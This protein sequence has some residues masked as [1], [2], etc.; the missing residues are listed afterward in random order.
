MD[1]QTKGDEPF[2]ELISVQLLDQ[3]ARVEAT[4]PLRGRKSLIFSDGRQAASRL[5]G[6][7]KNFSLQDSIRPLLLAGLRML[8]ERFGE[9]VPLGYAYPAILYA[10]AKLD[11]N[12][13][14]P[15]A[16]HEEFV[17][18]LRKVYGFIREDGDYTEFRDLAATLNKTHVK[19]VR[20]PLA[21]VLA[22]R[23]TGLLPLAL[24]A[25]EAVLT[26]N[27]RKRLHALPVPPAGTGTDDEK[28][29]ALLDLWLSLS[30]S[31]GSILVE[32]TPSEWID[33]KDGPAL[34]RSSG[35]HTSVLEKLLTVKWHRAQ[36]GANAKPDASWID[37]LATT[38]AQNHNAQGFFVNAAKVRLR[39]EVEVDW[40]RCGHCTL[41]QPAT[42]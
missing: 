37:F 2:Q 33:S 8:E 27:Q 41:A 34:K 18:D 11:V 19:S 26:E 20:A 35:R 15:G 21:R 13:R 30:F 22:N 39:P 7:L 5:S 1:H 25:P 14:L 29:R 17:R 40:R 28:R 38:F 32:G 6:K 3:P 4:S 31:A 23:H 12:F 36:F 10:C 42:P 24:A 9:P 16:E